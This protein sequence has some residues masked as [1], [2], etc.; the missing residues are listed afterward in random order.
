M[1]RRGHEEVGEDDDDDFM[2][3]KR[4]K[5][6]DVEVK[7]L[8]ADAFIGKNIEG[9]CRGFFDEEGVTQE[10]Y[11]TPFASVFGRKKR[12][13]MRLKAGNPAAR[14]QSAMHNMR[15]EMLAGVRDRVISVPTETTKDMLTGARTRSV[16]RLV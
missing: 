15:C 1:G 8:C 16:P 12:D 14:A 4:V 3:P 7:P 5:W 2:Q 13:R 9:S 6:V 10:G 11:I